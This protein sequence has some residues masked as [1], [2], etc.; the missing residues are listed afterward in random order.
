MFSAAKISF[1]KDL[2]NLSFNKL[3]RSFIITNH[4][5]ATPT[6]LKFS[7]GVRLELNFS[8]LIIS[9]VHYIACAIA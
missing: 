4:N 3:L 7:C 9:H 2:S 8:A 5:R 6:I 1:W